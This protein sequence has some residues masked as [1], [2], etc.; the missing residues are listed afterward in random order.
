M[1]TRP[2]Y[3]L[4]TLA[5]GVL[6][7][8]SALGA[9]ASAVQS[10]TD[11]I[12][13]TVS[14]ETNGNTSSVTALLSNP[15]PDGISLREAILA[16][17]NNPG[18]YTIRFASTLRGVT[19]LVN[20]QL[21]PLTGGGVTI[22]GDIDGDGKP[23]VTIGKSTSF[24]WYGNCPSS[25]GCG[26]SIASSKNQ[27]HALTLVGFGAGVD[28]APRQPSMNVMATHQTLSDN[29]VSGLVMHDIKQFG[30]IIGSMQGLNCGVRAGFF[31]PCW[32]FNT[33]T[34]TTITGNTIQVLETGISVKPAAAGDRFE[35]TTV[36]D[37]NIQINGH[38]AG[39]S[40]CT[41]GNG[42]ETIISGGLIARNTITGRTDIGIGLVAG[43]ERAEKTI[44]ENV[45]ILD[46]QVNLV[47]HDS[48]FCCQGIIIQAGTD[49]P[50]AIFPDVL[51]LGYPDGN[52]TRNILVSGNTIS[53]T[54]VWGVSLAS[55]MGSGGSFNSVHDI[56]FKSNTI[57]SDT[58]ANA[59]LIW[60]AGGHPTFGNR[61]A[62]GN[63]IAHVTL[64]SN[65]ITVGGA[66]G[67]GPLEG[68][69][70]TYTTKLQ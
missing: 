46:N 24:F 7:L 37:N 50:W 63:Q 39:I 30:V 53:G 26:L 35:N 61:L 5:A 48:D 13:T 12:V 40:F 52:Q 42:T 41:G 6:L 19:I 17:N 68:P 64:D 70:N 55:G 11:I 54:L 67:S 58:Q 38:D 2:S 8:A 22:E 47:S 51:P 10:M 34:N 29:V 14:D 62:T 28:I 57:T 20:A 43:C 25:D 59:V 56:Q 44:V 15:G 18:T 27:L 60:T 66:K 31:K 49:A 23:D 69:V 33:W 9:E 16:T 65:R 45:R 36:T 32:T 1:R 21:P 4:R 3:A